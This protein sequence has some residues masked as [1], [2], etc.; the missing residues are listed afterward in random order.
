MGVTDRPPLLVGV[1]Y[2]LNSDGELKNNQ[3]WLK[4]DMWL[5]FDGNL[6]YFSQKKGR[7]LVLL[8][9]ATLARGIVTRLDSEDSC[10]KWSFSWHV[11]VN[12][13]I[14]EDVDAMEGHDDHDGV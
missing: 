12:K 9:A 6:C 10:M 5:S 11:P 14:D 8:D 1:L 3:H 4:R 13:D 7:R 2:K